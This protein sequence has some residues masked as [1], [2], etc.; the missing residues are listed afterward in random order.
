[1]R[2]SLL[3]LLAAAPAFA[4]PDLAVHH[5]PAPRH[6][7]MRPRAA[8]LVKPEPAPRATA[9]KP[10][11]APPA[12]TGED[13]R[14]I[15]DVRDRI[16]AR[17]NLG[18]VVDGT[19][20]TGDATA[21]GYTPRPGTDF[22]TTR[23]YGFGESYLSTRGVGMNSL[24]TYFAARFQLVRQN[25]VFDPTQ[26][27]VGEKVGPPPILTWFDRSG[28]EPRSAWAEIKD[29]L[30]VKW[31]APVRVR[32][33]EVYVYGPWVLHMYGLVTEYDGKLVRATVYGGSRVPDYTLVAPE[34]TNRAGIGG[35]T[36]RFDLRNLA[37]PIPFTVS[38]EVLGFTAAGD[39][40]PSGHS[41]LEID[42][43]PDRAFSITGQARTIGND[44]ANE[45]LQLRARYHE[46]TNFVF[47]LTH[48]HNVDWQWDP[49]VVGQDINSSDP[50]APRRYLDLGPVLPQL[51]FSARG[52]TLI[53]ENVDV[54]GRIAVASDLTPAVADKSSYSASYFEAG[55][56]LELRLRRTI[57]L[58]AS[59]LTRQTKRDDFDSTQIRDVPG[60]PD[61]LPATPWA[62]SLGE[63]GFTEIGAS[64]RMT[65]GARKFS[66]LA[67]I[68]GRNTRYALD[69][70]VMANCGSGRDTGLPT[71]DTR[72]GGRVTIDAWIGRQVR[73]FASYDLSTALDFYPEITG[74]KS[75][76]LMMEGVY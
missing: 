22:S 36:V 20:L 30:P 12:D 40:K 69:Y 48:R 46:L 7:V 39:N 47:D 51:L 59:A 73:L 16:S 44:L 9:A 62:P 64:A 32:A 29:F 72:G 75:L 71:S 10:P 45:H 13:A 25:L 55:G 14:L 11:P 70:C 67:E 37:T 54:Y 63:R 53:A 24:S 34:G 26:P 2:F 33:G 5:A 58:G 74:Y 41:Q 15:R 17:V 52:G 4:E 57:A 65:L 35:A 21:S 6:L 28:F 56:A 19:A 8:Q 61:P 27:T 38:E 1:M 42:W 68:Y 23:A 76:K 43:R 66:A 50:T 60:V 18:Y 49:S 3:V 31:L